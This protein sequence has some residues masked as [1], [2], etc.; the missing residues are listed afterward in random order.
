MG[1]LLFFL[2]YNL[3]LAARACLRQRPPPN[4]LTNAQLRNFGGRQLLF[5]AVLFLTF[6][7]GEWTGASQYKHPDF[8]WI[9]TGVAPSGNG[10]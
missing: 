8:V 5:T 10:Y 2:L 4:R 9:P 7:W 3:A 1:V 6:Q